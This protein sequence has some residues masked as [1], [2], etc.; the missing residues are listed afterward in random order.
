MQL[1]P[2]LRFEVFELTTDHLA[3]ATQFSGELL[4]CGIDG[5]V[6]RKFEQVA[7]QANVELAK[8][9]LFDQCDQAAKV[10]CK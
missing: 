9:N 1:H 7:C 5:R 10:R 2:A 4:M 3:R 6:I 8:R